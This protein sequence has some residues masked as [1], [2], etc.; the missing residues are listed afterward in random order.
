MA[1]EA[2]EQE[3]LKNEEIMRN[4]A[5]QKANLVVL[6]EAGRM[7]DF[8]KYD[9]VVKNKFPSDLKELPSSEKKSP[10]VSSFGSILN[11]KVYGSH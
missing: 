7:A 6:K 5:Q 3:V 4:L 8:E 2:A 1:K 11:S 9:I 10:F